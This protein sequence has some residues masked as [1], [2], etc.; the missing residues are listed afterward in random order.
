MHYKHSNSRKHISFT[1]IH[2]VTHSFSSSFF[3]VN[4]PTH[5]E[6]LPPFNDA[7][8][9]REREMTRPLQ[10]S[11]IRAVTYNSSS[12]LG[13]T[14]QRGLCYPGGPTTFRKDFYYRQS[15]NHVLKGKRDTL[16]KN[17]FLRANIRY[18]SSTMSSC[19]IQTWNKYGKI[20]RKDDK[21]IER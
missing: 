8:M 11:E 9:W 13:C 18:Q 20:W 7:L 12:C 6:K 1:F 14:V 3:C 10:Q 15:L 5:A 21:E 2:S 16:R 17:L 19:S 4:F